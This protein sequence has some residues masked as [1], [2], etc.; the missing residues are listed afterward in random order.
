MSEY[1]HQLHDEFNRDFPTN[2]PHVDLVQIFEQR[3]PYE[4]KS[5][6]ILMVP[7][8]LSI[9]RTMNEFFNYDAHELARIGVDIRGLRMYTISDFPL[10]GV[11]GKE[12]HRIREELAFTLEGRVKWILEDLYG[13]KREFVLGAGQGIWVK[14]FILH[15][16]EV[17]EKGSSLLIV[18]NT[19]FNHADRTTHDTYSAEIF[20]RQVNPN[21]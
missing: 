3:G 21:L 7:V 16:Y 4:T 12:F 13:G 14:P 9:E 11:G 20:R 6:G 5:G 2:P 10:G 17:L 15:T 1:L 19:L 18:C 8:A